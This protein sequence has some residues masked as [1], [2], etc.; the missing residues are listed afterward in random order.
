MFDQQFKFNRIFI[1]D[2]GIGAGVTDFL[3]DKLGRKVIGLN[4]AK[5]TLDHEK[6]RTSKIFKEDLYSHAVLMMETKGKIEII[7]SLKLLRSL[8]SMTFEYTSDKNIKIFGKY[9]HLAEAF[10]RAC[11]AEKAKSLN[12]F[13][14]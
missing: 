6:I 9:S 5:R 3:I 1:D 10:V 11:W 4:N 14:L 2:G 13:I 8:K 12:L 7:N